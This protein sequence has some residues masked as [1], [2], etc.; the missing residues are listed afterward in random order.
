MYFDLG[1]MTRVLE[2]VDK[3]DSALYSS[4]CKLT[5]FL[6]VKLVP[7]FAVELHVEVLDELGV[8]EIDKG[9]AHIA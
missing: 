9:I 4:V 2:V 7:L 5:D 8:Y 6:T 3:T 1:A